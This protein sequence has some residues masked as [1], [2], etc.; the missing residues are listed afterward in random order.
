MSTYLV[1]KTF[2]PVRSDEEAHKT[3]KELTD[4]LN[5]SFIK[6]NLSLCVEVKFVGRIFK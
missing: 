5:T 1:S 4:Y 6:R 3:A 2:K